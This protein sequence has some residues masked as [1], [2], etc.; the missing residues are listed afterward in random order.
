MS[1]WAI[2]LIAVSAAAVVFLIAPA[3]MIFFAVFYRKKVIPFEE[4]NLEKFKN[5]YYLPYLGRIAEA[6]EY[7]RQYPV[8]HVTAVSRDGL[9]LCG[10]YYDNGSK[11]TAILFHGIG[12]EVYT[13]LSSQARFMYQN[14]FN[15][16]LCCHR[17]HTPS[18][19]HWTTIGLKEQYDVITWTRWAEE[20]GAEDILLYGVSM[21]GAS[22]AYA[23]DKLGGTRVRAA[24]IDSGFYSVYEQ[25][26]RDAAKMHIPGLMVPAQRILAKLFLHVDLKSNTA[27]SLKN[28][29][30]PVLFIHGTGDETVECKWGRLNYEVCASPKELLIVEGAPHTLNLLY[31]EKTVGKALTGFIDKYF[32]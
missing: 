13:N 29:E 16:L 19:G 23:S 2:V 27:D 10:D 12:A 17:A 11:R 9:T 1:A 21:G 31:D 20:H 4:Y 14:G 15:V 7:I 32:K 22:V 6:R 24:V 28:S 3:L 26:L 18:G 5:H 8:T 30:V 25:M